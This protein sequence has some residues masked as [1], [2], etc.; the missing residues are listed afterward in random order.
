MRIVVVATTCHRPRGLFLPNTK[1]IFRGWDTLPSQDREQ[2][3][4]IRTVGLS[5][6]QRQ[7]VWRDGLWVV[8][9]WSSGGCGKMDNLFN[10]LTCHSVSLG[11]PSEKESRVL[12]PAW[13]QD[14]YA[15]A[16]AAREAARKT[17]EELEASQPKTHASG[18]PE[19][20]VTSKSEEAAKQAR[21][22]S[23]RGFL[24][25]LVAVL[26]GLGAAC[27]RP[28]RTKTTAPPAP[29]TNRSET[30]RVVEKTPSVPAKNQTS[31]NETV[32]G[33]LAT[34]DREGATSAG[35]EARRSLAE[36]LAVRG[37]PTAVDWFLDA[38]LVL[39]STN[40]SFAVEVEKA[41]D[42]LLWSVREL[43]VTN[44]KVQRD[45]ARLTLRLVEARVTSRSGRVRLKAHSELA[46]NKALEVLSRLGDDKARQLVARIDPAADAQLVVF[47]SIDYEPGMLPNGSDQSLENRGAAARDFALALRPP[48]S[49]GWTRGLTPR[50]GGTPGTLVDF[51]FFEW[52]P[53][54]NPS[55]SPPVVASG[56]LPPLVL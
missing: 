21:W 51:H 37:D 20:V 10:Y 22:R 49:L 14:P 41:A 38:A 27:T 44:R 18:E 3:E 54:S 2:T 30:K 8:G 15:K 34:I 13:H 26:G 23:R 42:M 19:A 4:L 55:Y 39:K 33:Y 35:T 40:Q 1:I 52:K 56:P 25:L 45:R 48:A 47:G 36:A 31:G 16:R 32:M 7:A 53:P 17:R 11:R 28:G 43:N 12:K 5:I 6:N 46:A 9:T 29:L 24:P 50:R